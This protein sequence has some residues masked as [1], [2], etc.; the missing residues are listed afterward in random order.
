[1]NRLDTFNTLD[2][3]P[4]LNAITTLIQEFDQSK[5]SDTNDK[6]MLLRVNKVL[7]YI[8]AYLSIIDWDLLTQQQFDLIIERSP[9][10]QN[11]ENHFRNYTQTFNSNELH[12]IY[13]NLDNYILPA[14]QNVLQKAIIPKKI[15]LKSVYEDYNQTLNNL[16]SEIDEQDLLEKKEQIEKY[17]S[18]L[19]EGKED[20]EPIKSSINGIEQQ[21][22]Q[23]YEDIETYQEQLLNGTETEGSI[24]VQIE[25]EK[26]EILSEIENIQ[27]KIQD[28]S[29]KQNEL[30]KFY[31]EIFGK[32]NEKTKERENGL[33]QQFDNDRNEFNEYKNEQKTAIKTIKNEIKSH[34][35][36]A[37]SVG[38]AKAFN[39]EVKK[40]K[41][42]LILW[43]SGFIG[44]VVI[45]VLIVSYFS[46]LSLERV[47]NWLD[48][49]KMLPVTFPLIWLSIFFATRRSEVNR[50]YH[51]YLHKEVIANSYISYKEQIEKLA[52]ND[53]SQEL[54]TKL[55]SQTVEIIGKNPSETLDKKHSSNLPVKEMA[56]I[57]KEVVKND[58]NK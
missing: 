14:F 2:Y 28:S 46:M 48:M 15:N 12:S 6:Y 36:N 4:R 45:W 1:M 10:L 19:F 16:L 39:R 22:K 40:L 7:N 26:K 50:L 25:D 9:Y 47:F 53:K 21:I 42:S 58:K 13:D 35:P 11:I 27:K 33:S 24:K 55:L 52:E 18:E 38:L 51:E 8:N 43:N 23:W 49:L 44:L 57:A 54:L 34:M 20:E 32:L 41:T 29:K 5:I 56:E 3:K 31:I 37:M 17:H 30:N